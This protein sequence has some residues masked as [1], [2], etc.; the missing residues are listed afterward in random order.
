VLGGLVLVL[1]VRP[2]RPRT[3]RD[4]VRGPRVFRIASVQA[5]RELDVVVGGRRFV[6]RPH[7]DGWAVDGRAVDAAAAGAL[8]DLRDHVVALRALD[9]FRPRDAA[10]FGLDRPRVAIT[11]RAAGRTRTVVL[12][13]LN[14]V[15]SAVYARREGD[16]RVML[17]GVLILSQ[18]EHVLYRLEGGLRP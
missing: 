3:G 1:V 7:G 10:S 12:G 4:A 8:A 2:P 17:V 11:L 13:D 6:A 9:V 18:L 15:G 16:P 14:A 5:V